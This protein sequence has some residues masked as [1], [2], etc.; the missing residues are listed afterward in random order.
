MPANHSPSEEAA[1]IAEALAHVRD[2]VRSRPPSRG[3][4]AEEAAARRVSARGQAELHWAVTA[5]RPLLRSPGTAGRVRGA[6]VAPLKHVVRRLVRWYVEPAL[7][8]Q[9]RFN[10]A[11][12]QLVDDLAERAALLEERHDRGERGT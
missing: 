3:L 1:E 4:T 2:E 8:E 11:I 9:R 10:L 6:A 12:L 7:D 5:E